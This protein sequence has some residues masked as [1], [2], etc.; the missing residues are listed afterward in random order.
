VKKH[1]K[2]LFYPVL[3]VNGTAD[4]KTPC[5]LTR[6]AFNF[7]PNKDEN[8]FVA[9]KKATHAIEGEYLN[10]FIK[11]TIDWLKIYLGGK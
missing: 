11:Y 6:K 4:E 2:K 8:K 5:E 7:L 1:L 10:E 9:V 3:I